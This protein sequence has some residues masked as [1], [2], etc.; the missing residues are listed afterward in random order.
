MMKFILFMKKEIS[1][2]DTIKELLVKARIA[3]WLG[4]FFSECVNKKTVLFE[5]GVDLTCGYG[6]KHRKFTKG[7]KWNEK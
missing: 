6:K 2:Y 1:Y 4:D 7:N 5:F 3:R